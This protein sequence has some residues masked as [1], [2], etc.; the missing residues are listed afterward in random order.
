MS[1]LSSSSLM[2]FTAPAGTPAPPTASITSCLVRARVQAATSSSSSAR[3]AI[4]RR[5]SAKR[6]SDSRSSRP[7]AAQKRRQWA[8]RSRCTKM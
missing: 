2:S 3:W 1:S 4:R 8:S 6:G 7:I 5:P